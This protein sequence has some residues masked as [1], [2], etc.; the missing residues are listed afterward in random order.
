M[1]VDQASLDLYREL[2]SYVDWSDDDA[3]LVHA[4]AEIV[5]PHLGPL[6]DDFYATIGRFEN[7]RRVIT[8]GTAQVERLKGSLMAWIREL[9]EGCY[10]DAYFERRWRVGWR[11]V[12]IGLE[13]IYTH[14]AMTRMR[15]GLIRALQE[16]W[17]AAPEQL[18]PTVRSLCKLL[19]LDLSIIEHAYQ[20][21]ARA[22]QQR[23]ERLAAVGQVSGGVAHEL[24]NPLNVVKTSVYYLLNARAATVEKKTEHL[25]RIERH[26]E[27]ADS[28]I[29]ALSNFARLPAPEARAFSVEE[30]VREA[31][32]LNPVSSDISVQLDGLDAVPSVRADPR[33]ILIVLGNLI[34]NARDAMPDGGSLTIDARMDGTMVEIRVADT[35]VGIPRDRLRRITEPLFTTKARGLG[36]GLALARSILDK[37]LGELFVTSELGRGSEFF[38]RLPASEPVDGASSS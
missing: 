28:V 30:I 24:R 11:H 4:A 18:A 29:T 37:N 6:V 1:S 5:E 23:F 33:Q 9:F 19:D 3:R 27:L 38:V 25:Q 16:H 20:C 15:I 26:V 31:I 10:D 17:T 36:L 2:Q 7:V 14:A 22:R 34:R 35:G 12:E 21:E 32:E 8:G 13:Q